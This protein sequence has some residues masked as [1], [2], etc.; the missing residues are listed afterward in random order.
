MAFKALGLPKARLE[1]MSKA[2][3]VKTVKALQKRET[4]LLNR[5]AKLERVAVDAEAL[6]KELGACTV[7]NTPIPAGE[8]AT[9]AA[10]QDALAGG[11]GV[12]RITQAEMIEQNP[13]GP[14][15]WE[16]K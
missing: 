7:G 5:I 13:P 12:V 9:M 3:L 15:P 1:R 6:V 8:S 16:Q 4:T 2:Q 10:L 11:V 14:F